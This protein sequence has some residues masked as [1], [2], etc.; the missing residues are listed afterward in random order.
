MRN[1][2][3]LS[4]VRLFWL[5]LYH[6]FTRWLPPSRG[7]MGGVF[8]W[9]RAATGGRALSRT[10][11]HINLEHGA[12]IGKA[13][14]LELGSRSSIGI[15]AS[16]H[17]PVSI[18]NNVMMGPDVMVFALGHSSSRT[19]VPMIDQGNIAPR[20]VKIGDDVWIGARVIILPGVEIGTGCVL[21]AGSVVANSIP[22]YSVAVGNPAQVVKTRAP[23]PR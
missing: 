11:A 12:N 6:G 17:G 5:V 8:R 15:N 10:G 20:P 21:G 18:G 14:R 16:I 2:S 4:G 19:D 13:S 1:R 3:E 23:A 22:P 9:A 7:P